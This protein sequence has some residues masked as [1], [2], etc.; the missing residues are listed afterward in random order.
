[1]SSNWSGWY[2][3]ALL[4][5]FWSVQYAKNSLKTGG[6]SIFA[7]QPMSKLL[8]TKQKLGSFS[9]AVL[10]FYLWYYQHSIS[11]TLSGC[12]KLTLVESIL[13]DKDYYQYSFWLSLVISPG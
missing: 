9:N 4:D 1:M 8:L 3:P 10:N 7:C 5:L 11:L 2:L 6:M 12:V 13:Q